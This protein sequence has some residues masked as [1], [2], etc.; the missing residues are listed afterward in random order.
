MARSPGRLQYQR[1]GQISHSVDGKEDLQHG[2]LD[3]GRLRVRC[4]K[5]QCN[6]PRLCLAGGDVGNFWFALSDLDRRGS[7]SLLQPRGVL[8]AE[9]RVLVAP[10]G[11]TELQTV[12]RND[13]RSA[14]AK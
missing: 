8:R 14:R 9:L 3:L 6:E 10:Q 12:E 11:L 13:R 4:W 1:G 7:P 2:R 5:L